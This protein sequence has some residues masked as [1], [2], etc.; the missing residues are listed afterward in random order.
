[1]IGSKEQF[2]DQ[3]EAEMAEELNPKK[4]VKT[5]DIF[6][7]PEEA[8]AKKKHGEAPDPK[9]YYED[10]NNQYEQDNEGWHFV[11]AESK[12]DFKAGRDDLYNKIILHIKSKELNLS[13]EDAE[14]HIW[15]NKFREFVA[16]IK[17]I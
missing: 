6:E 3:R 4:P 13:E 9:D 11:M 7:T 1:M 8:Y 10:T 12:E 15:W 16:E 5:F 14:G 2:E 17:T